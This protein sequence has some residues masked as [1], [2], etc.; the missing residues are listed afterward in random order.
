M[1]DDDRRRHRRISTS[2][3]VNIGQGDGAQSGETRDVSEG[4]LGLVTGKRLERGS[5]ISIEVLLGGAPQASSPSGIKTM[6]TVMWS[7]ET[8]TGAYTAG[9]KFDEASAEAIERLRRFLD[10]NSEDE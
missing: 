6:A 1:S 2:V 8:D 4:G 9:L 10:S 3:K 5:Q 7:A